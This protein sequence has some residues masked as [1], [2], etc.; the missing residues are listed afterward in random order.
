M[1]RPP[2]HILIYCT[3]SFRLATEADVDAWRAAFVAAEW[4]VDAAIATAAPALPA[5]AKAE[6]EAPVL[7]PKAAPAAAAATAAEAAPA[8]AGMDANAD[9]NTD[10]NADTSANADDAT[11][12]TPSTPTTAASTRRAAPEGAAVG[13]MTPGLLS[14]VQEVMTP[15]TVA[16]AEDALKAVEAAA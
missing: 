11:P 14:E 10:S 8:S 1:T 3:R 6:S 16:A 2:K 7:P 5:E 12:S 4:P 9:A 13:V 15:G